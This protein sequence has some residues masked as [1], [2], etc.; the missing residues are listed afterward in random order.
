MAIIWCCC[1][2]AVCLGPLEEA[3][4]QR[5]LEEQE[6]ALDLAGAQNA[7]PVWYNGE[8]YLHTGRRRIAAQV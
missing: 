6:P 3:S 8:R 1:I 4:Y 2:R 5:H 7:G